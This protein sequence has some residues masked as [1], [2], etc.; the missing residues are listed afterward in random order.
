MFA[1]VGLPQQE[2][3][4]MRNRQRPSSAQ[5]PEE[6]VRR[7]AE[8]LE[9]PNA[10]RHAWESSTV[11]LQCAQMPPPGPGHAEVLRNPMTFCHKAT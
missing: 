6:V 4:L 9:P 7:M 8:R 11:T 5:V 2:K 10:S 1:A 3:A